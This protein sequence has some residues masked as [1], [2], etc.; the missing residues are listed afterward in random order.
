MVCA[1]GVVGNREC[2]V[3]GNVV[4]NV[5]VRRTVRLMWTGT[6]SVKWDRIVLYS[7]RGLIVWGVCECGV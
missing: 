1:V 6:E 5:K 4:F 2:G 3:C 7:C